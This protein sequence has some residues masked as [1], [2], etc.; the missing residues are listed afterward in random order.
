MSEYAIIT[1]L[2]VLKQPFYFSYD[3]VVRNSLILKGQTEKSS[4]EG[5]HVTIVRC[6]L[7]LELCEASTGLDIQVGSLDVQNDFLIWVVVDV[8]CC[9]ET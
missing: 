1:H 5:S 2:S 8:G 9:L 4:L 6:C 7:W 3:F